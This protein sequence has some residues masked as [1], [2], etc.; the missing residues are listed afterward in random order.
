MHNSD[1]FRRHSG[2]IE[3]SHIAEQISWCAAVLAI[4]ES[5]I[6][7]AILKSA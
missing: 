7:I 2:A 1:K 4:R 6:T 5:F 3:W